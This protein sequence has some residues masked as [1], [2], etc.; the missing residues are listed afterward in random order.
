[1]SSVQ[2][3]PCGYDLCLCTH[4]HPCYRGWIDEKERTDEAGRLSVV[5]CPSCA[6]S[7]IGAKPW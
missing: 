3:K 4:K 2:N 7:R 5:R 1:M 6:N